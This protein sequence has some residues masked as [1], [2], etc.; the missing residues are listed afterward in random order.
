MKQT[1]A[2]GFFS[3]ISNLSISGIS[4][5]S[6]REH[7][8]S[9][10]ENLESDANE[11]SVDSMEGLSGFER[12]PLVERPLRGTADFVAVVPGGVLRLYTA[13]TTMVATCTKHGPKCRLT[14]KYIGSNIAN[15]V[16]QGRPIGLLCAW[17]VLG[18]HDDISVQVEHKNLGL[19]GFGDRDA[20]RASVIDL[21]ELR[22]FFDLERLRRHGEHDEPLEIP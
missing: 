1:P 2:Q 20:A 11:S 15:R 19:P 3:G 10:A 22:P 18:L 6:R 7:E 4:V 14:R 13:S 16:G 17:L 5:G 12:E 21:P 9:S 8:I